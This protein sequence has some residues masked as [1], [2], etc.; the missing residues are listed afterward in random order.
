LAFD[1]SEHGVIG[2]SGGVAEFIGG[3]GAEAVDGAGLELGQDYDVVVVRLASRAVS[4][5]RVSPLV[6][7]EVPEDLGGGEFIGLPGDDGLD[8][9]VRG[10]EN[11]GLASYLGYFGITV[12][13]PVWTSKEGTMAR[14]LASSRPW[15][16]IL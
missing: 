16:S 5:A 13:M 15:I 6:A 1:R 9:V 14:L 3:N 2:G 8:F 4:L 7:S 11:G 12:S 10:G